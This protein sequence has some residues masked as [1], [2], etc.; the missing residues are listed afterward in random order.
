MILPDKYTTLTES[1]IGLSALI[2]DVLQNNEFT[3]EDVWHRLSKKYFARGLLK[4]YPTFQKFIYVLEFMY[5]VGMISYDE[6]GVISNENI[7]FKNQIT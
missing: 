6:N 2:L 1:Y 5:L 3:V 4:T 7:K